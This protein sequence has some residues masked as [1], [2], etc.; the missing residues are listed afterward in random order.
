[1]PN[2][3]DVIRIGIIQTDTDNEVAWADAKA[4][5]FEMDS[6]EAKKSWSYIRSTLN[7]MKSSPT[8]PDII[9]LPELSIPN[10]KLKSLRQFANSSGIIIIGGLDY[11]VNY[12]VKKVQNQACVI[13][14]SKL[15]GTKTFKGS[16]TKYVGKIFPA[17]KENDII[18]DAGF[19]FEGD[20]VIWLFESDRLG[21]FGV[22]IC[23]DLMDLER[24]LIYRSKIH[25]L[26]VLAY[27]QDIDTFYHLAEALCRTLY[28]NVVICNTGFHGGSLAVKP[29]RD[30]WQRTIYR[31]EGRGM[32]TSQIVELPV[33]AID[34]AQ[35][36]TEIPKE[37]KNK[38]PGFNSD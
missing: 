1:M 2:L 25:N 23:Y 12:G 10:D 4:G 14:P 38:P 17:P 34:F 29:Y 6:L 20:D 28:C 31:H 35:H 11:K 37:L 26:F 5:I 19:K 27:N 3:E 18:E 7:Q 36:N 22:T 15:K 24:A 30:I 33:K 21:K 32:E 8:P 13:I 16:I 9:I